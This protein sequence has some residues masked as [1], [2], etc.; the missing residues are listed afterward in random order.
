VLH[1][2]R[3][4]GALL[5]VLR[6]EL[7]AGERLPPTLVLHSYGGSQESA[8]S[9]L[10]LS[11]KGGGP[12]AYFGFTPGACR[13]R[14]AEALI[15]SLPPERLLVESDLHDS[16]AAPAAVLAAAAHIAEARGWT[17]EQTLSMTADNAHRAFSCDELRH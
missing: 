16:A 6:A 12:H 5:D 2:V 4:H 11:G 14:R 7:E 9:L 1:C 8:A 17:T 10:R 13:L 15:Q 3:A